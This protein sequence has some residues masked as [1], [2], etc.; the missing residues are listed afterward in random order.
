MLIV[1]VLTLMLIS[2]LHGWIIYACWRY[3]RVSQ[4]N[5]QVMIY[6]SVSVLKAVKGCDRHSEQNFLSFLTQ[7]YPAPVEVIFA[8]E[9]PQ[10]SALPLIRKL[11]SIQP[12]S[13]VRLV[14][15]EPQPGGV[16]KIHKLVAAEAASQGE[17]LVV[18]DSDVRVEPDYLQRIAV[19][20]AMPEVGLLTSGYRYPCRSS[21]GDVLEAFYT[22]KLFGLQLG[23]AAALRLR[24]CMGACYAIRR[25]V[26]QEVGGFQALASSAADDLGLSRLVRKNG[27]CLYLTPYPID[28]CSSGETVR[29]FLQRILRWYIMGRSCGLG[30]GYFIVV[31][32][33]SLCFVWPTLGV[34][35]LA[36]RQPAVTAPAGL[37]LFW[38]WVMRILWAAFIACRYLRDWRV[39]VWSWLMPLNDLLGLL[40]WAIAVFRRSFR[41]GQDRYRI[42]KR[43]D[44]CVVLHM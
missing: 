8:L 20:L 33:G 36:C 7:D 26:L 21:L 15:A 12:A 43:G 34:I 19:P 25:R 41:W 6:P 2:A 27:Y 42:V 22:V 38:V 5:A 11:Q 31:P 10:C 28:I 24:G 39:A 44:D 16:E 1:F 3:L 17:V 13:R 4:T 9:G 18:A 40:V 32:L 37:L 30:R 14:F 35:L 23:L 29:G